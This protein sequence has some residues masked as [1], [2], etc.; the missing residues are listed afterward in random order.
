MRINC[1]CI[2]R[3]QKI[4]RECFSWRA[5]WRFALH[6]TYSCFPQHMLRSHDF[7]IAPPRGSIS[8][9]ASLQ[10]IWNIL[11]L[12]LLNHNRY[13][14][15]QL[16]LPQGRISQSRS[17]YF[18]WEKYWCKSEWERCFYFIKQTHVA[19]IVTKQAPHIGMTHAERKLNQASIM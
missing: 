4:S 5:S 1:F 17:V 6:S 13:N 2:H 11:I 18:C 7:A 9:K 16:E 15:L 3:P 19:N 14:K 10:A 12:T 8:L